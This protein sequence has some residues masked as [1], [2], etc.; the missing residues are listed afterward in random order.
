MKAFKKLATLSMALTFV[1]GLG[2]LT[3]CGGN[4]SSVSSSNNS[5]PNTSTTSSVEASS[6][7]AST[8]DQSEEA[9]SEEN[10]T[11]TC[12]E[13]IVLDK[14]GNKV[15]EGY[16]INLCTADM[17]N[18]FGP[19]DVTNGECIFTV[20]TTP[21]EYV[22]H[23]LDATFQEVELKEVVTTSADAFGLYILQLAE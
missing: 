1:L 8:E 12:Y 10:K 21:G 15:G 17:S 3:A 7:P 2:V 5:T 18:C 23:V 4:D 6:T 14:D 11:Y 9:S 20:L 16:K 19:L 13:F 22:A